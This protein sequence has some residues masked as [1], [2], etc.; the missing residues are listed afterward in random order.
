MPPREEIQ[1]DIKEVE[2]DLKSTQVHLFYLSFIFFLRWIFPNRYRELQE[3]KKLQLETLQYLKEKLQE[4]YAHIEA[5]VD[6][7]VK[8]AFEDLKRGFQEV[9]NVRFKWR[10]VS[11]SNDFLS[12][13]NR[14]LQLSSSSI[15]R[16]LVSFSTGRFS[17]LKTQE[18][19]LVLNIR[20]KGKLY[21][22]CGFIVIEY[23]NT[24]D[25]VDWREL[26]VSYQ[27]FDM[28]EFNSHVSDA[29]RVG[30]T[31]LYTNKDGSPDRRYKNNAVIPINRY[32]RLWLT[33]TTGLDESYIFSNYKMGEEFSLQ[34]LKATIAAED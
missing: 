5:E 14:G 18:D 31:Y 19:A 23:P 32:G 29:Q 3:D 11:D 4:A 30:E 22:Y 28:V 12:Y 34:L 2:A 17:E 9:N 21:I 20:N 8:V 13:H 15:T 24:F 27:P 10:M 25:I 6:T 1:Q 33:T 7:D 26:L 16:D